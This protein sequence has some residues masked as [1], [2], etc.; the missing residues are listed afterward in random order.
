MPP[1]GKI[2]LA[3]TMFLMISMFSFPQIRK[4][5][6]NSKN[7]DNSVLKSV[8]LQNLIPQITR[9]DM[10]LQEDSFSQIMALFI[11]IFSDL[12][13]LYPLTSILSMQKQIKCESGVI[14]MSM[15]VVLHGDPG[16]S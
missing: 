7:S 11:T 15:I 3:S 13:S 16:T 10:Q 6:E 2:L 1:Y 9:R 5:V 4:E 14:R 8:I 12:R